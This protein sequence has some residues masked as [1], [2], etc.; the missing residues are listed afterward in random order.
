RHAPAGER[1]DRADEAQPRAAAALALVEPGGR[2]GGADVDL[3][4]AVA[5]AAPMS[6]RAIW[7]LATSRAPSATRHS[8]MRAPR[9]KSITSDAPGPTGARN[10]TT[11]R[12]GSLPM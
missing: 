11:A 8:S 1:R 12:R 7:P 5:A 2:R 4:G 3:H 6:A 9:R 10:L